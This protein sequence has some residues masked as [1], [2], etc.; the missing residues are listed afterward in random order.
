M[1]KRKSI[2]CKSAVEVALYDVEAELSGVMNFFFMSMKKKLKLKNQS[3][4]ST[5][6]SKIFVFLLLYST[7]SIH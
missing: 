5:F 6:F 1:G 4:T 2:R 3:H 7:I